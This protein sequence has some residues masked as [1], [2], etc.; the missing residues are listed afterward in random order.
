M[1][2]ELCPQNI[3]MSWDALEEISKGSS[4]DKTWLHNT[5]KIC[6]AIKDSVADDISDW[7]QSIWFNM[8][9]GMAIKTLS[10]FI[11]GY[12]LLS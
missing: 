12:V 4:D 8:A 5:F 11:G 9:M 7:L 3:R 2:G 1:G 10:L 6:G